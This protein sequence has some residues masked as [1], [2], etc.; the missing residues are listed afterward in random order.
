[1]KLIIKSNNKFEQDL[2]QPYYISTL[3]FI[4]IFQPENQIYKTQLLIITVEVSDTNN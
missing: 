1:M 4:I 3:L 2:C